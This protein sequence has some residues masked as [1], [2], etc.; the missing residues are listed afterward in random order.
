MVDKDRFEG[1]E[2]RSRGKAVKD[3]PAKPAKTVTECSSIA[4]QKLAHVR[5]N[6]VKQKLARVMESNARKS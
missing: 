3:S 5:E 4:K 2:G 6:N 1:D